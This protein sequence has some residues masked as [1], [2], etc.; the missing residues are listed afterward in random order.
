L[1]FVIDGVL[2]DNNSSPGYI[3]TGVEMTGDVEL[4]GLFE[5]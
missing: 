2:K 4:E 5:K 3:T 1:Y